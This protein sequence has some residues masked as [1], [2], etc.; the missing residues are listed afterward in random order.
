[1]IEDPGPTNDLVIIAAKK[2][3]G[4]SGSKTRS[5]TVLEERIEPSG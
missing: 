2:A 4:P 1:M 3:G 5:P